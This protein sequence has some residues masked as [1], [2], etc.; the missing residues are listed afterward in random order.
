MEV[1]SLEKYP[2]DNIGSLINL[3]RL[4]KLVKANFYMR[5]DD[6]FFLLNHIDGEFNRTGRIIVR[7]GS[8]VERTEKLL[9]GYFRRAVPKPKPPAPSGLTVTSNNN[10]PV[11]IPQFKVVQ[12]EESKMENSEYKKPQTHAVV[13]PVYMKKL[14]DLTKNY[15]A[16]GRFLGMTGST[17]NSMLND[18]ETRLV[19]ELACKYI[20]EKE[21]AAK[22][23]SGGDDAQML[24]EA[25]ALVRHLTKK[26]GVEVRLEDGEIKLRRVVLE[27]F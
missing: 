20:Y 27:D 2:V 16:V 17:I 26:L 13:E 12:T 11:A 5:K 14:Y 7:N 6:E 25:I 23:P 4:L 9:S 10:N 18:N 21:F 1:S 19:N 22:V 3:E 15:A 8:L 24:K